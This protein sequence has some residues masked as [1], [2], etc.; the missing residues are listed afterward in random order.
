MHPAGALSFTEPD[1]GRCQKCG[2]PLVSALELCTVCR[3]TEM[4]SAIDRI[5]PIYP[6]TTICQELLT[7][8]KI[9]GMRGLSWSFAHCLSAVLKTA[10]A[11]AP[12]A[13]VPVPP[14]PGKIRDKGWDQV[15]E[16]AGIL[17]RIY[18]ISI[19][20]CL[21]RTSGIQ[22]KK[23]GRIGRHTN[24][25]GQISIIEGIKLPDTVI[26]LDD[27]M[28][29]GSTLDSCADVLKNAGCRKVYGLT[30]FFD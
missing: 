18:G 28:T 17:D 2:R 22:Q 11:S 16:L 3:N 13:L 6:Y 26:L 14:R 4:L 7:T 12:A 1:P 20:R 23:L 24:M 19:L 29:T 30:L 5:I 21:T 25:K 27:L 8:W 10:C 15:E 9:T